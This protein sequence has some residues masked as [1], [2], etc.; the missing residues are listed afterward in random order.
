MKLSPLTHIALALTAVALTSFASSAHAGTESP[1]EIAIVKTEKPTDRDWSIEVGS[2]AQFSNIRSST[3]DNY[4]MVPAF[5]TASLKID[6]VSLDEPLG[7]ILRGNTE[8]VFQGSGYA[9]TSGRESRLIGA[10]FGPR[11]NFVQPGWKLVPFVEGLVGFYFADSN[12]QH[13]PTATSQI[14]HGLGQ[15]FNFTFGVA[16]GV[17]YD[18]NDDWFTRLTLAYTHVSNAGLSEPQNSNRAIDA[19]GPEVSVGRRF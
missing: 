2:G 16:S 3:L 1:K 8:F 10:N 6:D 5:V 11:Y 17:R 12:Q 7:G 19:F 14:E 9:I 15:D 4:T 13:I 18:I